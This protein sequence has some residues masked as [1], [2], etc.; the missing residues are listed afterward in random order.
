MIDPY[1]TP[2]NHLE[3]GVRAL[4]CFENDQL[5]TIADVLRLT[6]VEMMRIPNFGK[7]SLA[8]VREALAVEGFTLGKLP[9]ERVQSD[10][11]FIMQDIT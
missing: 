5:V 11:D 4:H 10:M 9:F 6:E 3:I 7:V 1:T 8:Q 2:I